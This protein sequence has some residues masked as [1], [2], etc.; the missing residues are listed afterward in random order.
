[1]SPRWLIFFIYFFQ[2][3]PVGVGGQA[4]PYVPSGKSGLRPQDRCRRQEAALQLILPREARRA[5]PSQERA[6]PRQPT[7][8]GPQFQPAT[9][10]LKAK[11]L[12]DRGVHWR[13]I[14]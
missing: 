13:S 10:A 12:C 6:A 1:M 8:P 4:A 11:Q 3:S 5:H 14:T 9:R 2:T 7:R